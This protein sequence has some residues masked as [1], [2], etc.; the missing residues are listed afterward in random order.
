MTSTIPLTKEKQIDKISVV[1][2]AE[3]FAEAIKRIHE[4]T[5]VGE[6]FE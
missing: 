3:L 4:A 2:I 1:S 5:S 6:F